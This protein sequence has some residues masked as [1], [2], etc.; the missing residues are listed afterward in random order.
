MGDIKWSQIDVGASSAAEPSTPEVEESKADTPMG[1]ASTLV[2]AAVQVSPSC[3]AVDLHSCAHAP[4]VL[5]VC[6]K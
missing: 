2:G 6:L 1:D 5:T 4:H 3:F